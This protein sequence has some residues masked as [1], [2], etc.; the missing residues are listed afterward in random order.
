VILGRGGAGK[1]VLARRL[2]AATGLPCTELDAIF[3]QPGPQGPA[4]PDPEQWTARLAELTRQEEWIIDGD[5]GPYDHALATRLRAADTVI[6][7][8]L[9]L[10]RC[11]WRSLR[12]GPERADYWHWVRS[13]RRRYLPGI[14]AAITEHAPHADVR[15]LRTPAGVTRFIASL[16][17]KPSAG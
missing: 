12:R 3:W 2:A 17:G 6:V 10:W 4:V 5:L 13:Y 9:S 16:P 1:S 14:K 15:I 8:D 11:A 7:L